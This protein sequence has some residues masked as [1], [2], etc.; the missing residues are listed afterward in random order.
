ML[1]QLDT[2]KTSLI[3]W[4]WQPDN[5]PTSRWH[6]MLVG[7]LRVT[8]LVIRDLLDGLIT[9]RAMGLVY[10]TLLSLVPLLAV[11][12]SVL[13]GFG[14]HNQVE[15]VLLKALAPLGGKGV[16]IT[17]TIIGFVENMK[18]GVLGFVGFGFLIFTVVSL[19]QKIERAFNYT[20]RVTEHRPL[21]QRFSNY[22][23][24]IL[25]GPVLLFVAIGVTASFANAAL[26]RELMQI[27]VIG[28]L[29]AFAATFVP[30]LLVIIAFS[31]IYILVP[32]TKV[33]FSAAA[34]GAAVAGILWE[35]AGLAFASFVV[36]SAKYTAI[37][38]A[39]ATLI[40]FMIW[41]YLS[42]L[43]LLIGSNIAFY[44]QNPDYRTLQQRVC[45]LSNRLKER[46]VLLIMSLI[47]KHFYQNKPAW[48]ADG[49]AQALNLTPETLAPLL[50]QLVVRHILVRTDENPPAFVPAQPS[51]SMPLADIIDAIRQADEDSAIDVGRLSEHREVEACFNEMENAMRNGLHQKTLRDLVGSDR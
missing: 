8:Y 42:W 17:Q 3:R 51:E 29:L 37:Y 39:F 47:G 22:L 5:V 24:V 15:P 25:I 44:Y 41:V 19:V 1:D 32:N 48:T 46:L 13:K 16:E 9:L 11:S 23:S 28:G 43:I 36:N 6:T 31:V 21:A 27:E 20:W 2:L 45:A 30:Y 14:V 38:S 35:T 18:A 34:V 12:F 4:I 50:E 26:V 49:L 33:N 10:T 7:V 40:L